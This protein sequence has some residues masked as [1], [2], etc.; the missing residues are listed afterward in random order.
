MT[1]GLV[2]LLTTGLTSADQN[3]SRLDELFFTIQ[4]TDDAE[5]ANTAENKIW[6][7][8][9][10]HDDKQTQER[11][12]EGIAAMD[13]N[14]RKALSIFNKIIEDVP[15]FAE[16]WNKRATLYYLFGEHAASVSDIEMT[17][18]LEPRH[19]G[20]LSGLGLVYMAENQYVKAKAA[21][22]AVLLIHPHSSGVRRNIESID[23]YLSRNTI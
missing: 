20:A 23:D 3:D 22:E 21:F 10:Q 4:Q 11:L 15:D 16:G 12:A 1:A 7:I 17:L 19:F 2:F 8:W 14:P 13:G 18:V 5:V 9:I 6:E